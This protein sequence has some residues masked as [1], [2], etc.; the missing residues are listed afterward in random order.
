MIPS[1][2]HKEAL[3]RLYAARTEREEDVFKRTFHRCLLKQRD[4]VI[5]NVMQQPR[6]VAETLF[7]YKQAIKD[8][9]KGFRPVIQHTVIEG[10]KQAI[11]LVE[12]LKQ[13]GPEMLNQQALAWIS[14]KSLTLAK[15]INR[16]TKREL[17]ASLAEGFKIGESIPKLTK[18]V[19]KVY[20]QRYSRHAK[21]LA[22]TETIRASN[23]GAL[24][25]YKEG[26]LEQAEFYAADDERTCED[27][28]AY[29]GK[30]YKLDEAE[31]L[32]P[33]HPNCR[34]TY[35][36]IIPSELEREL[37]TE[38]EGPSGAEWQKTLTETEQGA[39]RGWGSSHYSDFRTYQRT[40]IADPRI[41]KYAKAFDKALTKDGR[42]KGEVWRG[43]NNIDAKTFNAIKNSKTL[44]WDATTS[45]TTRENIA[46][47]FARGKPTDPHRI[48]FKI[49]TKSGVDYRVF[50]IKEEEIILHKGSQYR[51]TGQKTRVFID[52]SKN[53]FDA[54]EM[55]LEEI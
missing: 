23:Y 55:F 11:G 27:C 50:S 46:A 10:A 8:F 19:E 6:N 35:L 2:A 20:S 53:K 28:M 40:G 42:Y 43:I 36:P 32:I 12:L 7:D 1:E 13:F 18:R 24:Q 52:R 3:W 15:G 21:T 34:C 49:K 4:E 14:S 48:I 38:P 33:V 5:N 30:Y 54:L 41:K 22:R 26:G 31:G 45:A 44:T 16:T 47:S 39:M 37:P 17:Q 9:K 29:H 25:G 51:V